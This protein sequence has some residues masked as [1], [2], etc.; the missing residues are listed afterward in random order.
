MSTFF[1]G[2]WDELEEDKCQCNKWRGEKVATLLIVSKTISPLLSR[3]LVK[4]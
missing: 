3:K 2:R 4:E 1:Y